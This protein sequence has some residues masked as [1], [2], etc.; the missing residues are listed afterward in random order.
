MESE[1]VIVIPY[2]K[3]RFFRQTLD[4]FASQT[5]KKFKIFVGDDASPENPV[6]ILREYSSRLSI[7]YHRFETNLGG[8]SLTQHWNRCVRMTSEPWVWLFSDDDLAH[9]RCV[10][11]LRDAY[12]KEPVSDVYRFEKSII[13]D[14]GQQIFAGVP[15][16]DVE[17]SEEMILARFNGWRSITI[18]EHVFSRSA[19]ERE[20]GF[21]D[22]PLAWF[23]DDASWAAMAR[24][25]GIRTVRGACVSWRSGSYNVS[26]ANSSIPIKASSFMAYLMWV[27][28]S[29]QQKEFH[30]EL[31]NA[32]RDWIPI[33]FRWLGDFAPLSTIFTFWRFY[34]RFAGKPELPLLWKMLKSNSVW[35][36]RFGQLRRAGGELRRRALAGTRAA[37]GK[38][39]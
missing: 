11:L 30:S 9:P 13:N 21:V 14:A 8:T 34:A 2:Y 38:Q 29:F 20:G 5:C 10:E 31:T 16:P 19:F 24:Q 37:P 26:A 32:A 12:G 15:V 28:S 4:S 35:A 3:A 27:R 36:Y 25:T 18:P 33:G 23:S 22:F 6:D 17:S 39:G 1:L 7:T